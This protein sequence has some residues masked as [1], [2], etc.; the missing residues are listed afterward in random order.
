[1]CEQEA[2]TKEHYPPKSFFPTGYNLN[3]TTVPSCEKHNNA[4]SSDVEYVRNIIT[5]ALQSNN[6]GNKQ[7]QEKTLK[8][9]QHSFKLF[10]ATFQGAQPATVNGNE[11]R[12]VTVDM[13]RFKTVIDAIAYALYYAKFGKAY[14]G[15]WLVYSPSMLQKYPE[16]MQ[17]FVAK[18]LAA[19]PY[20]IQSTNN[21]QVFKYG[22]ANLEDG[23]VIFKMDFYE[24]FEVLVASKPPR[25]DEVISDH[26][27]V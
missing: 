13:V 19:I 26:S 25:F 15:E 5:L 20:T 21:P 6:T 23:K 17:V 10:S 9:F 11:T 4:N 14:T 16:D 8:S 1:M 27:S 3:L 2:T 12:S 18:T 24:G 22:I 7:F